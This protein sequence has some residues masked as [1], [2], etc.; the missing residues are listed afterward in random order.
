MTKLQTKPTDEI[1]V[2]D[3]AEKEIEALGTVWRAL[4]SVQ[5]EARGRILRFMKSKFGMEWPSNDY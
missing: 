1:K 2:V 3:S 5:P 4:D